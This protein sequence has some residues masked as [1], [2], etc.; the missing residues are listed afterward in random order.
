MQRFLIKIDRIAAWMSLVGMLL[1][2]ITGYGM[3][4]GII[5]PAF[6]AK[7]HMSYLTYIVAVAF[8]V[9]TS[10]A[11]HLAFRRWRIWNGFTATLLVLFY[12]F[13]FFGLIFVDRYYGKPKEGNTT[14]QTQ[15][16][17]AVTQTNTSSSST[18]NASNSQ[19]T[20]ATFTVSD[21]AKYNGK[22]GNPAYVAIDGKVYDLSSVFR[23][24]QHYSF[25]AGQDLS[26]VF[27]SQHY[28]SI[29][30]G[31]TIVGTLAK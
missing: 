24:G 12:L 19:S 22:N 9:H 6:A 8:V 31:Y 4:K 3:T 23:N 30:S 5:D 21:L 17:T 16:N 15:N 10:Y 27:H 25:S 7:I 13:L 1:Y 26:A 11:I 14:V 18:N 28:D 29:L 2:F 20:G